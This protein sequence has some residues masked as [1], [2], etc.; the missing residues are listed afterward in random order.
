M[1]EPWLYG[2]VAGALIASGYGVGH[3]FTD[4]ASSSFL[5]VFGAIAVSTIIAFPMF[6]V[7]VMFGWI[8]SLIT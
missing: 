2:F 7:V 5:R 4:G 3:L 1:Q 6:F 8:A